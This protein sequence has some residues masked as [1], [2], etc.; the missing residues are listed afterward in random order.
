ME[1]SGEKQRS[2][3]LLLT[4]PA[5][6]VPPTFEKEKDRREDKLGAGRRR[7][8]LQAPVAQEGGALLGGRK[9]FPLLGPVRVRVRVRK[10]S[11]EALKVVLGP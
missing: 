5:C 11:R 9:S 8:Q 1:K 4:V 7:G 3:T 10:L 2:P 6:R